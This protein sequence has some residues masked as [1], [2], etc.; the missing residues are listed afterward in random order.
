MPAAAKAAPPDDADGVELL[1]TAGRA[2]WLPAVGW[3]AAFFLMLWVL[4]A[5][6]TVPLFTLLYLLAASRESPVLAG[7]CAAA[8]WAF[9]YGL[10]DRLLRIPLP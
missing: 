1:V 10:F 3:M 5:L 8:S 4:G 2:E 9:V 6:I 7:A